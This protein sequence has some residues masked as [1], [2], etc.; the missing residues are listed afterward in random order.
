MDAPVGLDPTCKVGHRVGLNTHTRNAE[1][2]A[3]D[4]GRAR[5]AEWVQ[6]AMAGRDTEPFDVVPHQMRRVGQHES[7]P[8]MCSLIFNP[9]FVLVAGEIHRCAGVLDSI[10]SNTATQPSIRACLG[11][12][13]H[14]R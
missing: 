5:S 11:W 6:D 4:Q 13:W 12:D 10:R 8:V 7:I 2:L 1:F 9:K 14:D 3:L